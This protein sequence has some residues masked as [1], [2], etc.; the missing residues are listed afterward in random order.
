MA[1]IT[2]ELKLEIVQ[3]Q[4][5]LA[6]AQ[7]L[8]R[9]L[10]GPSG[11]QFFSGVESAASKAAKAISAPF[12]AVGRGMAYA[13]GGQIVGAL[14][15]IPAQLKASL[16]QAMEQQ[17]LEISFE[18]LGKSGGAGK[19]VFGALR[20]DA[21][22]T[23]VAIEDMAG[24]VRKLMAQG[25]SEGDALKISDSMLD[26]GGAVGM[27][28]HEI[29][30]LGA[31]LSQVA[32]KGVAN[33]EELRQQIAERGIPIFDALAEKRGQTVAELNKDIK[34]GKVD[35]GQVLDL[36]KNMEASFAKFKGGASRMAGTMAGIIGRIKQEWIDLQRILGTELIPV[37]QPWAQGFLEQLQG[38]KEQV[39]SFLESVKVMMEG[40]TAGE[41]F[42]LMG[43]LLELGFRKAV[44]YLYAGMM[45][46]AEAFSVFLSSV[47]GN[48]DFWSGI[49]GILDSGLKAVVEAIPTMIE[50]AYR[51][52][53]GHGLVADALDETARSKMD[54][55]MKLAGG[56]M[57]KLIP[58]MIKGGFDAAREKFKAPEIVDVAG[59]GTKEAE[60]KPVLDKLKGLQR[61]GLVER[62]RKEF[63][64]DGFM[65]PQRRL[66]DAD[67]FAKRAKREGQIDLG[68][69]PAPRS[70]AMGGLFAELNAML[71]KTAEDA[72]MEE[73]QR[74][75]RL[76]EEI[77]KNTKP[78]KDA[79]PL[80]AKQTA[81]KFS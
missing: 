78:K 24:N 74:H 81:L 37:L 18:A 75:T 68:Q 32:A 64:G 71:G 28:S 31:A 77:A 55:V 23:G 26:L 45:S 70:R 46:A 13:I 25:I 65:G 21:L 43:D 44:N 52:S 7:A 19:R 11:S 80:A 62:L 8:A 9:N 22:R 47:L 41:K 12:L 72:M 14:G 10:K 15:Q 40:M 73:N 53:I 57:E 56:G 67:Y 59:A 2:A 42:A 34:L 36:F 35:A 69:D 29:G 5:A 39:R 61:E 6:R 49:V 48:P 38:I 30:L 63:S 79:R 51:R 54:E 58:A 50:A 4:K 27:T 20:D 66:V 1:A 16:G 60:M 3:F 76:L 17:G 33:M